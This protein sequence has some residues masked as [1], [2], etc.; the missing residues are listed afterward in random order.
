L[1]DIEKKLPSAQ[2]ALLYRKFA[3]F[4]AVQKNNSYKYK[5]FLNKLWNVSKKQT[6]ITIVYVPVVKFWKTLTVSVNGFATL[7]KLILKNSF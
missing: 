2:L 4:N 7:I 3:V 1:I 6:L 5:L